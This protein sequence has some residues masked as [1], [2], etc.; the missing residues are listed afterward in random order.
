MRL[1][2]FLLLK[3]ELSL[4]EDVRFDL[5]EY[6]TSGARKA[7]RLLSRQRNVVVDLPTGAGKTNL[8]LILTA[9]IHFSQSWTR[10]KILYVVPTRVLIGQVA[11]AA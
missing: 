8:A 10:K 4:K 6:Q 7:S 3:S 2:E 11:R 5:R 1:T 9:L